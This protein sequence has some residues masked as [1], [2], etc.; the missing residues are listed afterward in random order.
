M[1]LAPQEVEQ[2]LPETHV[3]DEASTLFD[4]S[5]VRRQDERNVLG[6]I[7]EGIAQEERGEKQEKK[8]KSESAPS[9]IQATQH[10]R[11]R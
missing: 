6:D 11:N 9:V 2:P 10:P 7:L 5:E 8:M 1:R 3:H 4:S